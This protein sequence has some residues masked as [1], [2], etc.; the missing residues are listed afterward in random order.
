MD[1]FGF[2]KQRNKILHMWNQEM[3]IVINLHLK[4]IMNISVLVLDY[5]IFWFAHLALFVTWHYTLI[6][7]VM[8]KY[9]NSIQQLNMRNSF[10]LKFYSMDLSKVLFFHKMKFIIILKYAYEDFNTI[11]QLFAPKILYIILSD[12]VTILYC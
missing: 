6:D 3:E 11:N 4:V 7:Y 2:Y 1:L 10:Y 8:I 12:Y 9:V 5:Q